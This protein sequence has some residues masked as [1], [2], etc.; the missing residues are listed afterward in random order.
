M[1]SAIDDRKAAAKTLAAIVHTDSE[2]AQTSEEQIAA[3]LDKGNSFAWIARRVAPEVAARVRELVA[4]KTLKGIYFTKE[5]ERFYPNNQIA[6]QV[7][8]YVGIDDNGSAAWRKS[9]KRNCTGNWQNVY[10]RDARSR[11]LGSTRES[12]NPGATWN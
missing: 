7:L 11:V 5:F 6:A 12:L 8:G 4:A 2:D 1:P 10:R 9:L 3:R